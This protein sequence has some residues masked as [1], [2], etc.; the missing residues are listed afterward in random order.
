MKLGYQFFI[1]RVA[2]WGI[3]VGAFFSCGKSFGVW[4]LPIL[5]FML[6][7]MTIA[8]AP[9]Q[10]KKADYRFRRKGIKN[11][12]YLIVVLQSF[13]NVF[14]SIFLYAALYRQHG[15]IV[16]GVSRH[17]DWLEAT[18][19]SGVTWTTVGYGDMITPRSLQLI[20][21]IEAING[22]LAMAVMMALIFKH[23]DTQHR[24]DSSKDE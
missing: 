24:F 23:I 16:N 6:L 12:Q 15:L 13:I 7:L 9:E 1:N 8:T 3:A 20:P 4:L 5:V 2:Y 18:Y 22:Y 10:I 14:I 11:R 17:I 19:F 21:T